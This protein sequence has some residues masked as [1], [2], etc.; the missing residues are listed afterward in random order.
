MSLVFVR[1]GTVLQELTDVGVTSLTSFTM[2]FIMVVISFL[3]LIFRN[4]IIKFFV[5]E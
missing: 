2:L 1:A 3:P 5:S 4:Q